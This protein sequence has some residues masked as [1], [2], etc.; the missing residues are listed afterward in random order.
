MR[1]L[2]TLT[3]AAALVL[4]GFGDQARADELTK[5]N[6]P[7][8]VVE[9]P[10]L[11]PQGMLEVRG[12]TARIN[13][14]SDLVGDPIQLAPDFYYG[15]S[16]TLNVG[17]THWDG[18]IC[19]SGDLCAKSYNDVGIDALFGFMNE[20]SVLLALRG[21]LQI[22]SFDNLVSGLNL[23]LA[24]QLGAGKIQINFDPTLYLGVIGRDGDITMGEVSRKET[25]TAPLLVWYQAQGQTAVF[26]RSGI[27]GPL[28]G[29]G[30]SFAVPLGLGALF[31]VNNRLDLGGEFVF[32]NL[33]GKNASADGRWLIA[34]LNIRL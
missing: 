22:P 29:F 30:D 7:L 15:V 23:G 12:D 31:A 1:H 25:L 17:I 34:R 9:R 18:G 6:W 13:M 32:T 5:D 19:V 14:S 4:A 24:T 20:G 27:N 28:D 21:G 3:I 10:I 2:T 33:A 16:K 26:L 8:A 11:I